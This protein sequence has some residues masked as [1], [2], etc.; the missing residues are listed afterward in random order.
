MYVSFK[1]FE[2]L[3]HQI[4][5]RIDRSIR[6]YASE[7]NSNADT[8]SSTI[9]SA[10]FSLV[11]TYVGKENGV[12]GLI[13]FV[14]F[15]V[16]YII[17]F[18]AY[19]WLLKKARVWYHDSK[20]HGGA[21]SSREIKELI[22]NFDHIACDNNLIVRS[23]MHQYE[24]ESVLCLGTFEFYELLYY[25]TVSANTT[26]SILDHS[27]T[28]IN[29]LDEISR[30]DLHRI[31]NQ[32]DM[33][34]EAKEFLVNHCMDKRIEIESELRPV[35]IDQIHRLAD[36]LD[37]IQTKCDSFREENFSPLQV[38][39]LRQKYQSFISDANKADSDV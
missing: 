36:K 4:S 38:D 3:R 2:L 11:I 25:A 34:K 28:C 22:D 5:T 24:S 6:D 15:S 33:L 32:L 12:N 37:L 29:T 21:P 27:D 26:L 8:I 18:F 35:L 16:A 17:A 19:R 20:R 1:N 7:I 23:F 30:V 14:I 39:K 31:Y 13:Q 10:S 9:F